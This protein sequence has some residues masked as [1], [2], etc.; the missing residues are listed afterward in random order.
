M[1]LI[2]I[3]QYV[4][5]LVALVVLLIYG[6]ANA[7]VNIDAYRDYF[8]VGRF[9]EVCTMCEV[10]VL[11]ESADAVPEYSEIPASGSF[12][13]YHLQTRTFWS[14]VSTIWEWFISNF[15]AAPLA[16]RGHTRPVHI[17]TVTDGEWQPRKIVEARLVLDPGVLEFGDTWINRVNR[18]WFDAATRQPIGYCER[19]P[20]WEALE[21]ISEQSPEGVAR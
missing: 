14:Q 1:Q 7:Q 5:P 11:C 18:Q 15:S 21:T 9:G 20:L 10:T 19:L 8:L 4:R 16:A 17:H 13:I 2:H 12:T 3:T 6:S